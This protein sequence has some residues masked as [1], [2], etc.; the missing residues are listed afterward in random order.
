MN[1]CNNSL[2]VMASGVVGMM[3]TACYHK[4]DFL[5]VVVVMRSKF[6]AIDNKKLHPIRQKVV[7][8]L[9]QKAPT[10]MEIALISRKSA[11]I[12]LYSTILPVAAFTSTITSTSTTTTNQHYSKCIS[13]LHALSERQQQFWEDVESGLGDI[14]SYYKNKMGQDIDRIRL[15]GRR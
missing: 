15:F 4:D 10:K 12:M 13:S 8:N 11:W 3:W 2:F 9:M 7:T 6:R 1:D 5:F 14:E